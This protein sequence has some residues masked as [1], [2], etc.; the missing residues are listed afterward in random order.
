[1]P[2]DGI[3]YRNSGA[4]GV[5]TGTGPDGRLTSL[6]ADENSYAYKTAIDALEAAVGDGANNITSIT[7]TG[8]S[9]TFH[10]QDGSVIGP[11]ALPVLQLRFRGE[12]IALLPYLAF[13]GFTVAGLGLYSVLIDHTAAATFDGEAI[14]APETAGAFVA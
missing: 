2:L 4:W 6:E 5:G 9:I 1:M 13:D 14:G 11:L 10:F 7:S 12:W 8:A 3:K